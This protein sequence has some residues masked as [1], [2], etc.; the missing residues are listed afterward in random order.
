MYAIISKMINSYF[1]AN[2]DLAGLQR[3]Q[4]QNVDFCF[5]SLM[6]SLHSCAE[7]IGLGNLNIKS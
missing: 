2:K 5:C 3:T 4:Q 7:W 6:F 1:C